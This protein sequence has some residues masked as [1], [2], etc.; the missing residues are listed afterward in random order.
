MGTSAAARTLVTHAAD[1]PPPVPTGLWAYR[2]SGAQSLV[3]GALTDAGS[4]V[5]KV[6]ELTGLDVGDEL[7]DGGYGGGDG[8]SYLPREVTNMLLGAGGRGGSV[9]VLP[10]MKGTCVIVRRAL[11]TDILVVGERATGYSDT[12]AFTISGISATTTRYDLLWSTVLGVCMRL[13]RITAAI[14]TWFTSLDRSSYNAVCRRGLSWGW[15]I[16]GQWRF[17][18]KINEGGSCTR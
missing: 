8:G 10:F 18:G 3:G 7:G 11:D 4:A 17:I 5:A 2:V 6:C 16:G 14:R 12:A 13:G 15:R 1:S 9:D